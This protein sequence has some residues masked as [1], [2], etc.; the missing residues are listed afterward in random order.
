MRI[1]AATVGGL[2]V[3]LA[4]AGAGGYQYRTHHGIT[5]AARA[6]LYK[7]RGRYGFDDDFVRLIADPTAKEHGFGDLID[8]R[9]GDPYE[10]AW[11]DED[12]EEGRLDPTV[13]GCPYVEGGHGGR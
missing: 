12:H 4:A 1:R 3:T 6:F 8:S 2:I 9:A 11:L 10:D 7:N 13:A 5:G